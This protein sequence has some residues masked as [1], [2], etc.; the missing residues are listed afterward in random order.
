MPNYA[1][2]CEKCDHKF[3]SSL[4]IKDRD[5]PTKEPCPKCKKKKVIR[6]WSDYGT[7]NGGIMM[8][9]TLSPAKVNGSAWKE[10]IDRI[11][12]SGQVPKRFHEKLDRSSDFRNGQG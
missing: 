2:V 5:N 10:V 11:K 9:A 8:D 12:T 7:G 3:E 4:L 1:Y 6:D